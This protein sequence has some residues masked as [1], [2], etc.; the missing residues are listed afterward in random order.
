M[1]EPVHRFVVDR[2][3]GDLVVVEVDGEHVLD[4]PRWIL[5]EGAREGDVLVATRRAA[6]GDTVAWELRVDAEATA[7]ARADARRLVDRLRRKDPG[8]DLTL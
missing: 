6:A 4:L 3:E 8:G 2:F 1:S 7:R 5:P